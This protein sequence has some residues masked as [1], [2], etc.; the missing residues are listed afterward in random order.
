MKSNVTY[1]RRSGAL[2]LATIKIIAD[3]NDD[4]LAYA[5]EH[6]LEA[7]STFSARSL[8]QTVDLRKKDNREE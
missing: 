4:A 8:D 6:N 7:M 3:N 1:W 5:K 2:G